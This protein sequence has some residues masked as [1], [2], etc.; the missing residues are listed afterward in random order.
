MTPDSRIETGLSDRA[1][2]V[3]WSHRLSH[4]LEG[5]SQFIGD[6]EDI[7]V[8]AKGRLI[9]PVSFRRALT[10]GVNTFVVARWFDGC[11]AAF[12][13]AGWAQVIQKLLELE[14]NRR[15]NR[16]IVRALAGRAAEIS[17]DRQGRILLP[18]KHLEMAEISDRAALVGV[19]DR[20]EIWNPD[21]YEQTQEEVDLD[22]AVEDLDMF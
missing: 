2:R 9:V 13:P 15:Q 7:P 12:D 3:D 14:G 11:L 21:R 17:M 4:S 18:K 19:I 16:Q 10:P 1:D 22:A 6:F 5:P 8:D 20:I